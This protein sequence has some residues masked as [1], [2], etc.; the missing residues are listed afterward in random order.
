MNPHKAHDSSGLLQMDRKIMLIILSYAID[1]ALLFLSV[2][3]FS[4]GPLGMKE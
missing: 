4:S 1:H 2:Q 3:A